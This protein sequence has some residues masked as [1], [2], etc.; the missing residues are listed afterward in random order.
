M[1]CL[2]KCKQTILEGF[3]EKLDNFFQKYHQNVLKSIKN[4]ISSINITQK[5]LAAISKISQPTLSKLLSGKSNF[6]LD[7]LARIAYALQIDIAEITSFK[8]MENE[9]A[10]NIYPTH[11]IPENDNLVRDINRPAFKGYTGNT[12]YIYFYPTISSENTLIHGELTLRASEDNHCKVDLKIYTGKIDVSGN[13]ITKNYTGNMIISVSFSSCY[14]NLINSEIGELCFLSFHHMFLFSQEIICRVG[15]VLTT[16]SGSNR[17]P[18]MHRMIISKYP[19]DITK[20]GADLHFL[21]GQLKLN[22][23][24]IIISKEKYDELLKIPDI[25]SDKNLMDFFKEFE[26]RVSPPKEHYEIDE[27]QLLGLDTPVMIKIMG[28]S[29]LREFSVISKYNKISTKSDEFLFTY[30]NNRTEYT[31]TNSTTDI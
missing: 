23:S 4:T 24:R 12:Y 15:G 13:E 28:I 26:E 6:T 27:A 3:M 8:S 29:L 1:I 30:L 16:S 10:E 31:N 17:R 14:C 7:Q 22:N 9:F 20:E 5:E 21:K 19:F 11:F 25:I 2:I 18:T